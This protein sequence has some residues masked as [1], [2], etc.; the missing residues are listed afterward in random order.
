VSTTKLGAAPTLTGKGRRCVNRRRHV[1]RVRAPQGK[2]LRSVRVRVAGKRKAVVVR[3]KR[4]RK[5]RVPVV[6]RRLPRGTVRVTIVA[7]TARGRTIRDVR[8]LRTCTTRR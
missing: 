4:A 8:T 7:R 6:L 2:K 1:L 5:R 3:G